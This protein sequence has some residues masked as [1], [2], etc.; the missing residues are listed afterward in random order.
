MGHRYP[1][2]QNGS[3]RNGLFIIDPETLERKWQMNM[4][5]QWGADVSYPHMFAMDHER[6]VIVW[7]D[8]VWPEPAK[9]H[10]VKQSD[11]MLAVLRVVK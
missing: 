6:A 5:T 2:D 9:P 4:P 1:D 10:L 3:R 7:Y 8:G 11:I